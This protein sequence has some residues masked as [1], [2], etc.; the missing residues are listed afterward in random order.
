[1][2]PRAAAAGLALA[3]LVGGARAAT[4]TTLAVASA[5]PRA[6][7]L[8]YL[9]S[10]LLSQPAT[11]RPLLLVL[12]ARCETPADAVSALGLDTLVDKARPTLASGCPPQCPLSLRPPRPTHSQ[13][14]YIVAAPQAAAT[15]GRCFSP[16]C[17]ALSPIGAVFDCRTW[18]AYPAAPPKAAPANESD[19]DYAAAVVAAVGAAYD[20][21]TTVVVGREAGGYEA[22]ALACAHPRAVAGAASLDGAAPPGAA[23]ASGGGARVASSLALLLVS[24]RSATVPYD[25]GLIAGAVFPGALDSLAAWAQRSGCGKPAAGAALQL[26]RGRSSAASVLS[27][28][29][30]PSGDAAALWTVAG[31]GNAL[32]PASVGP[33]LVRF[34]GLHAPPSPAAAWLDELGGLFGR[35][36]L[37]PGAPTPVAALDGPP[38]LQ[39]APAPAPQGAGGGGGGLRRRGGGVGDGAPLPSQAPQSAGG[40]GVLGGALEPP[41]SPTPLLA[42][43]SQP[44]SAHPPLPAASAPLPVPAA[45]P[46][47]GTIATAGPPDA[48][49]LRPAGPSSDAPRL[50]AATWAVCAALALLAV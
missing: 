15:P 50:G 12:H 20:V 10:N 36:A 16:A 7:V 21:A 28:S 2:L 5:A 13:Y 33:Q 34:F 39:L 14:G 35:R 8:V 17:P 37:V 1:M 41:A 4:R 48:E 49:A 19:A 27:Y 29:G 38:Q 23:C 25:G 26:G 47:P 45:P 3:A 31:A 44:P 22:L 6:P 46:P 11:P 30:C 40:M 18:D 43:P 9:P 42:P 24:A 32:A